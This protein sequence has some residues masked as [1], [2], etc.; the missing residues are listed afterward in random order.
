MEVRRL[1]SGDE[2]KVQEAAS[3]FDHPP[4]EAAV[5]AFLA[6]PHSYLFV[7]YLDGRPAGFARAHAMR[8]LETPRLQMLLYEIG[9][10]P[11][12]RRR[13]AARALIEALERLC[14]ERGFWEMF[15][16]TNESNGPAMRLYEIT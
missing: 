8:C 9:V 16:I 3:L 14:R 5:R 13:G 15:V 1:T 4:D 12:Y 6:D 11:E 2:A 10:A 7:A